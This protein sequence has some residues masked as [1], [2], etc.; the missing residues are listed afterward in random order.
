MVSLWVSNSTVVPGLSELA[1]GN[2]PRQAVGTM[3]SY[4]LVVSGVNPLWGDQSES[5]VVVRSGPVKDR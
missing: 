3:N 2:G 1:L 4:L 5:A